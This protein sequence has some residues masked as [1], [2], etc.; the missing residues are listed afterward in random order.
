MSSH[1]NKVKL[2]ALYDNVKDITFTKSTTNPNLYFVGLHGK[3]FVTPFGNIKLTGFP[4]PKIDKY[5]K[6]SDDL[7]YI[8]I[9]YDETQENCKK[10]FKVFEAMDAHLSSDEFKQQMFGKKWDRY[11]FLP[12]VKIPDDDDDDEN[13]EGKKKYKKQKKIK[14]KF[15]YLYDNENKCFTSE[16]QTPFFENT[17]V[18]EVTHNEEIGKRIGYNS[19]VKGSFRFKKMGL[20]S[21]DA[22]KNIRYYLST[23]FVQLSYMP[24]ESQNGHEDY[25][26]KFIFDDSDNEEQ[27]QKDLQRQNTTILE[28]NDDE[29]DETDDDDDEKTRSATPK[30]I[31][32]DSS[33]EELH[34]SNH[35]DVNAEDTED[36]ELP[37]NNTK[38]QDV[39]DSDCE[40]MPKSKAKKTIV[41]DTDDEDLP[42]AKP[43][44]AATKRGGKK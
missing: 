9:Y 22:D 40:E 15:E 36:E 43:K 18:V 3:N 11:K 39:E 24:N 32:D 19:I 2:N 26:Q 10:L 14:I 8:E 42:K 28:R 38:K 23:V 7:N 37:K 16:L 30:Q 25:K 34:K 13:V 12:L 41:D 21:P 33:D 1:T 44:K 6:T 20:L 4:V 29:T 31:V 5:H 27:E 17:K 35:T